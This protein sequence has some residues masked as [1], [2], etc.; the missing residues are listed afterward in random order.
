MPWASFAIFARP[1][2]GVE[3]YFPQE[4]LWVGCR[5]LLSHFFPTCFLSI[6]SFFPP[7]IRFVHFLPTCFNAFPFLPLPESVSSKIAPEAPTRT[8]TACAATWRPRPRWPAAPTS[9]RTASTPPV[10]RLE[11]ATGN[12]WLWVKTNGTILHYSGPFGSTL[13]RFQPFLGFF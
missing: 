2:L 9:R 10:P 5:F 4:A 1:D 3:D 7:Q 8:P 6:S 11:L 12:G 13:T